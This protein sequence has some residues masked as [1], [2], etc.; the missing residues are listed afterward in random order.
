MRLFTKFLH[1][2]RSERVSEE[3]SN[4]FVVFIFLIGLFVPLSP[5]LLHFLGLKPN[6]LSVLCC[7]VVFMICNIIYRSIKYSYIY[8]FIVFISIVSSIF[9]SFYWGELKLLFFTLYFIVSIIAVMSLS[10]KDK[11]SIVIALSNVIYVVTG[12]AVVGFCYAFIGGEPLLE[13]E[14]PDK[15]SAFLY[16]STMTNFNVGLFIRPS[17]IFDEPGALS[18][19]ICFT[20]ALRTLFNL[21][22]KQTWFLLIAGLITFSVAHVIY[23]IF[24]YLSEKF[25]PKSLFMSVVAVSAIFA[26][27]FLN[28]DIYEVVDSAFFQRFVIEDGNLKGDNRSE[29]FSNAA[30]LINTETFLWGIDSACILDVDLCNSK[31]P[32]FGENVLSPLALTGFVVSLPYYL[33]LFMLLCYGSLRKENLFLIGVALLLFQ[34]PYL[35][36][37]GYSLLIVLLLSVTKSRYGIR[38][39]SK[40][41][42]I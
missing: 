33:A 10:Y 12:A 24:H 15:R 35:M 23:L 9:F 31:Y 21:P 13:I 29:L 26:I 1:K 42:V 11:R 5:I 27:P 32:M 41:Q 17:G 7:L 14:N 39:F 20:C 19:F 34:R 25:N 4:L 37:Y 22:K 2:N 16:L 38:H 3:Q 30:S 36:S 28:D 18:F 6:L 40:R 8:L